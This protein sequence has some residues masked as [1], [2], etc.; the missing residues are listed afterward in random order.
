MG[1]LNQRNIVVL[2]GSQTGTAQEVAER[3]G[4]EG[5]RLHF[6]MEVTSMDSFDIRQL[7]TTPLVVYVAST[8]GEGDE[9]SNM[10][11]T[12]KFLLR[13]SL[14]ADSLSSQKFGVI[15]LGDSSYTKFNH[16]AKKLN[17][18][19]LQLGAIQLQPPG[20]GDDQHDLGPDFVIDPWLE[21]FWNLALQMYP[22]PPGMEPVGKDVLPPPK[23][24]IT[25]VEDD[26]EEKIP[27]S[28]YVRCRVISCE[29]QT[30]QTHFQDVRLLKLDISGSEI[31]Y[32]PGDVAEVLPRNLADN[33]ETFMKLFP[34]VDYQRK[35][36]LTPTRS[37]TQLPPEAQL[38]RPCTMLQAVK[39]YFDIQ[40]IPR[41]YFFELLAHFTTDEM[42]KEKFEEFSR[43]DGQQDL[44]DYCNR[45]RRNILE[46]L[47]DFRHTTPNIPVDYLFDLIPG[48]K[49]RSF[50]IA[51][52]MTAHN[53]CLE[54]LVAKVLYNTVLKSPRRG[55][56]STWIS[57]LTSADSVPIKISKGT[58]KFP[59]NETPVIMIGP[60]T[61]VA[62]FRSFLTHKDSAQKK[63]VLYFGSRNKTAD[64]FFQ[65]D[66]EKLEN[67]ELI[68]AFSR[69]QED[70]IYVQHRMRE[71]Q[72]SSL[73]RSLILEKNAWVYV[74]GSSKNMPGQVRKAIVSALSDSLG[75]DAAEEYVEK[76]ENVG[77]YQTETWS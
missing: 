17:R 22:L 32:S 61:G 23:Y 49:P 77:R 4:R 69:D 36:L 46:V 26:V 50:S 40:S 62:P 33:V 12:W 66:F 5:E 13:K 16:V 57:Q 60:G 75:E 18:R 3:I 64:F 53:T 8:T 35:F 20:L 54:L 39:T 68:T 14:P 30:P 55:L 24:K 44:Y 10:M 47:H 45:P 73:I 31:S 43:A 65:N 19:L 28:D 41:R 70:K 42:E 11:K 58:L 34:N 52:N 51:S 29:R 74:A 21:K 38:P 76:M 71:T 48:I 59:A 9:P 1:S 7:P 67:L 15:G 63:A 25:W 2:F 56:C 27:T 72:N 37:K 6:N